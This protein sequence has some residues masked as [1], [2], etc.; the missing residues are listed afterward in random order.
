MSH[1]HTVIPPEAETA[2]TTF[3]LTMA[4]TK[5]RTRSQRPRT[6]LRWAGS[7]CWVFDKVISLRIS[8]WA[9]VRLDQ[10]I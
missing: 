4:T 7:D 3:R 10:A 1:S 2:G 6:R 5:R 8:A 9:K